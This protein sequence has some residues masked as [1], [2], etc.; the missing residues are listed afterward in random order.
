MIRRLLTDHIKKNVPD[1]DVAVLLSGGVDSISVA[2]AAQDAGKIV[3]AYSF[4]LQGH[5]S[6]DFA[7]AKD[8]AEIMGW[9]FTGVVVPTDNLIPDWYRL[10]EHGC[11]KKSHF[12]A[13]VYPFLYCYENMSEKFCL[14]G[15]G[16][17]AYFGCSKK[18]MIRYSSFK[19]KRN[20]VKYCKENNQ[21]R[22]NWNEFRNAY[23]DGDC[24]GYQ[25]HTN[26]A[27]KYGK[28]HISPY[29]DPRVRQLFMRYSWEELNKPKQKNMIRVEF[30][31]ENLLGKVKPHI[32]LQLG[33]GIDKLFETLLDD[34][35]I[36]YK[37]RQRVMD[38]CRDWYTDHTDTNLSQFMG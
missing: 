2:M 25:Q 37:K 11:R 14:T 12:E 24:A 20:Y 21:K 8:V 5:V 27:E 9:K 17:D 36:N 19:K 30:D 6:Y 35:I 22:V 38:M 26:L 1:T 31:I 32:N 16:A 28:V 18:A 4:H 29:L 10:V 15:W 3:H 34:P 13:A 7:K 23:L 33:G